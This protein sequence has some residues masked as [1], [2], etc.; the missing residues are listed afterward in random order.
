MVTA[1]E[2]WDERMKRC[3]PC[4]WCGKMMFDR[5]EWPE[6]VAAKEYFCSTECA[7]AWWS[8]DGND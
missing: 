2:K 3:G 4:D 8:K 6:W 7:E 5:P 1:Q